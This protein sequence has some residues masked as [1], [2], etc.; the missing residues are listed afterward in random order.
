MGKLDPRID[1]YI[2]KAEAFAQEPLTHLR[3][4]IHSTC[5]GVEETIKWN[6]PFFMSN[7]KILCHIASFKKHMVMGFWK[8]KELEDPYGILQMDNKTAMG[9]IGKISSMQD[10]PKDE[11]LA[12]LLRNAYM[13]NKE[14]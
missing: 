12:S 7:R 13:I 9:N 5:P 11:H 14:A 6:M 4:L 1:V 3:Q 10:L 2:S 8:A